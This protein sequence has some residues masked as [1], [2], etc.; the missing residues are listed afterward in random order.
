M[1]HAAALGKIHKLEALAADAAATPGEAR[2]ARQMAQR[3]R[4]RHH[5]TDTPKPPPRR[6][7]PPHHAPAAAGFSVF[8]DRDAFIKAFDDAMS[9]FN[10]NT[11]E[12][13]SDRVTVQ[14]YRDRGNWRI[15]LDI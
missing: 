12:T 7:T 14:Y 5:I 4:Q 3:L 9:D 11:G 6:A 1:D 8:G 10:P 2:T 13:Q 15:D